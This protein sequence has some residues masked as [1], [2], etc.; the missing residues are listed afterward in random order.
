M[1]L[2]VANRFF[3]LFAIAKLDLQSMIPIKAY[4][5][6]LTQFLQEFGK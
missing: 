1:E 4:V 5:F 3:Q 2:R 6:L